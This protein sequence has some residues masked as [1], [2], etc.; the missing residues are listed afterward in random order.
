MLAILSRVNLWPVVCLIALEVLG[1]D[2]FRGQ[3]MYIITAVA[4]T[5]VTGY[6]LWKGQR[7][8]RLAFNLF[9]VVLFCFFLLG[10]SVTLAVVDRAAVTEDSILIP[11][12]FSIFGAFLLITVSHL[13]YLKYIQKWNW[14]LSYCYAL[15]AIMYSYQLGHHRWYVRLIVPVLLWLSGGVYMIVQKYPL[16]LLWAYGSLTFFPALYLTVLLGSRPTLIPV[17]LIFQWSVVLI[18]QYVAWGHQSLSAR[19]QDRAFWQLP[20][21]EPDF[22]LFYS[23]LP[24]AHK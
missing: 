16:Q 18:Y 20:I 7:R 8:T 4:V 15:S 10:F 24:M 2:G 3:I 11:L 9:W 21:P 5:C 23:E 1:C 6:F 19:D 17:F 14:G 13:L 22:V 12:I